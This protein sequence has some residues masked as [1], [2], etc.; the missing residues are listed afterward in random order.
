MSKVIA[1]ARARDVAGNGDIAIQGGA[2]VI[3]QYLAAN[4]VDEPRLH[5]VPF[6][7]GSGTRLFDG[8]PPLNLEQ[9]FLA[10]SQRGHP[11]HLP[12]GR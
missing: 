12:G 9:G 2:D 6:A 3:N 1:L 10:D 4:P 11:C 5:T 8:V 7:L